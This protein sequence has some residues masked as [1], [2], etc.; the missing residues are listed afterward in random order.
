MTFELINILIFFSFPFKQ[1]SD[2][3]SLGI[4]AIEM[5]EGAPRKYTNVGSYLST[6]KHSVDSDLNMKQNK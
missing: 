6:Q 3:W 5:A 2:I 1:Q 4:T